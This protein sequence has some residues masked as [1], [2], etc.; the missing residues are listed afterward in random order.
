M[1]NGILVALKYSDRSETVYRT[2]VS[3]YH[4]SDNCAKF[5][6][7]CGLR[8]ILTCILRVGEV[9]GPWL[10]RVQGRCL[11]LDC[12]SHQV[13]AWPHPPPPHLCHHSRDDDQRRQLSPLSHCPGRSFQSLCLEFPDGALQPAKGSPRPHSQSDNG[14]C[15]NGGKGSILWWMWWLPKSYRSR[16]LV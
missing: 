4:C 3:D 5:S 1:K 11:R 7:P 10:G 13:Q 6:F 12:H 9:V 2:F 16:V 8:S 15:Y 14:Q